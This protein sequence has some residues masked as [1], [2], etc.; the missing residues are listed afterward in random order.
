MLRCGLPAAEGRQISD[1]DYRKYLDLVIDKMADA[2][3]LAGAHRRADRLYCTT[4]APAQDMHTG[5]QC[6]TPE[7][8]PS[9]TG[10][11]QMH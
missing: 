3:R 8:L 11:R 4:C 10:N 2:E 1:A 7:V 6:T 5:A 9:A